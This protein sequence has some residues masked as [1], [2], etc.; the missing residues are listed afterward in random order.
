MK[1][2]TL[3][4][5]KFLFFLLQHSKSDV[6]I[7]PPPS[8]L[9]SYVVN[10]KYFCLFSKKTNAFYSRVKGTLFSWEKSEGVWYYAFF[11]SN[12]PF[13]H[14]YTCNCVVF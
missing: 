14:V 3:V 11:F 2:I 13:Y 5:F 12:E 7:A 8:P 6:L 10:R 9:T 4:P 1:K